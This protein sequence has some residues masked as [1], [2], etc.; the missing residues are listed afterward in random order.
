[1]TPGA[2]AFISGAAGDKWTLK[3]NR[4]TYNDSPIRTHR[5]Q[6]V[7]AQDVDLNTQLLGHSLASPMV[8]PPKNQRCQKWHFLRKKFY[9]KK[10]KSTD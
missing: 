9:V 10:S 8:I 6:S 2:Y 5:F 3:E 1:M 7:A 4:R